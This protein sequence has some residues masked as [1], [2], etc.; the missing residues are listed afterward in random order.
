MSN[1]ISTS[2]EINANTVSKNQTCVF[3]STV[4]AREEPHAI[5]QSVKLDPNE[6]KQISLG[7]VSTPSVIAFTATAPVHL[8]FY[9]DSSSSPAFAMPPMTQLYYY[10]SS[11]S[12]LDGLWIKALGTTTNVTLQCYGSSLDDGAS[13]AASPPRITVA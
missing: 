11:H 10:C 8:A 5:S 7:E 6:T 9:E 1:L 2:V 3:T 13:P 4:N 12:S